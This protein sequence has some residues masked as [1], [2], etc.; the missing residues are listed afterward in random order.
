MK[1]TS[2][3]ERHQSDVIEKM[4]TS[5]QKGKVFKPFGFN[6]LCLLPFLR[7]RLAGWMV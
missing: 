4:F 1:I 6:L 3:I 7:S 5:V 2:F